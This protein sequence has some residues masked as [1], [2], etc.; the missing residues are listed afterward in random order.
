MSNHLAIHSFSQSLVDF[1]GQSYAAFRALPEGTGLPGATFDLLSSA[2]FGSD[3]EIKDKVTVY[4]HRISLNQHQRN[5]APTQAISPV[6]L[7]LHF[8]LTPWLDTADDELAVLGWAIREL[9]Y[10]AFL[11]RSALS[12]D[13]NW[14]VDE[15]ISLVPADLSAED[16]ARIWEAARR[17]YRLSYP[18][19]A[20]VVRL[21]RTLPEETTPAVARRFTYT[22]NLLERA[23]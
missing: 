21:G 20:R 6:A 23:P 18:F 19:L 8:L 17:G 11:D 7:D 3:K 15:S 10:H 5:A 1:L 14:A 16:M 9:H 22:D 2:E 4:L 13:A 12:D